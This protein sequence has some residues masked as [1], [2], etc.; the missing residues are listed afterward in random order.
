[1]PVVDDDQRSGEG[2]LELAHVLFMDL[3]SFSQLAID[4]QPQV[5]SELQQVVREVPDVAQAFRSDSLI[6]LDTGD[7]MALAFFGNPIVPVEI[8]RQVAVVLREHPSIRLRMGIHT[9]PVYRTPDMNG[10]KNITGGGI[11]FAQRVMDCGDAGHILLSKA[12]ADT[13]LQLSVWRDFV[14]D[15]GE[16]EVKHGVRVHIFNVFGADFGNGEAPSRFRNFKG[17]QPQSIFFDPWS[18]VTPPSFVGRDGILKRLHAAVEEGRSVS[19]VGDWRIGKSSVLKTYWLQLSNYGRTAQLLNGSGREGSSPQAFVECAIGW[20]PGHSPDAAADALAAWARENHKPGLAPALLVDEFDKLVHRFDERFFE[21]LRGMMDY[22]SLIVCS[23]RE[24]D[25]V[26]KDLGK[27][28]PFHNRLELRWL[29][30][31][32]QGAADELANRC[33]AKLSPES[34]GMVKEWA[35]RHPFFIQLLGRKLTDSIKFGESFEEAREQFIAEGF[36]RLRELWVTLAPKDQ[37][38]LRESVRSPQPGS[39]ALKRRGL[40]T[41]EGKPF[42]RLLVEWIENESA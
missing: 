23:R 18:P 20:K 29:G 7:G 21:R 28:S 17:P 36:S 6:C 5:R 1:M 10:R 25:Q 24:L 41:E 30:L 27:T 34:L 9:G 8:A 22:L 19:L 32:E 33:S 4:H 42:G 39:M 37:N 14:H 15:L 13:L 3:V 12:A 35:G 11:N 2:T 38:A 40:L 31:L 16:M 26:Y